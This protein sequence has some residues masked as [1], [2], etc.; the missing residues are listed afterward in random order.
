MPRHRHVSR[1]ALYQDSRRIS[2]ED[3]VLGTF[4]LLAGIVLLVGIVV[5]VLGNLLD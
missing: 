1:S 2:S 3:K 4:G 5:A